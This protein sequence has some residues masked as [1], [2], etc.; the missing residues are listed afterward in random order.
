[1]RY[2]VTG[3]AG[4][5][6]SH[7]CAKLLRNDHEVLCVDNYCTGMKSNFA[8]LREQFGDK[9]EVLRHD[10]TLP[11]HIEVD[12]IF[13]LACP[14]SPIH[15]QFDPIKTTRTCILGMDNM[16]QLAS[17]LKVPILQ[18]STSE[19]YGDPQIHP[20][21]EEYR[22]W[23]DQTGIRS[24]Y[25]EG[26]RCAETLCFDY[27]RELGVDIKV[28]RIFNSYGPFMR[29]DDGRVVSNFV[30]QAL[31]D[32]PI[33]VYGDGKQ[34]RSFC[35]VKD[36][37]DGIVA[38]MNSKE[39]GPINIGNPTEITIIELV[40]AVMEI[41][42]EMKAQDCCSEI[43]HKDLPKDDPVR[44]CPDITKARKLIGWTPT[45]TLRDGL[46][47]TIGYFMGLGYGCNYAYK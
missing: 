30:V 26:K 22:G 27:Y 16:L 29:S 35:F 17:R 24:C 31:E 3:G 41:V 10:I 11:L 32:K 47:E 33:T 46:R 4:F 34:T 13:N 9:F 8:G 40:T 43:I 7:L 6:G 5:L 21:S 37:I 45:W 44:R 25:D 28:V 36:T 2:A 38:M 18:A 1:M 39:H 14:A 12:G 15:Y 19:V 23:V 20:Q 42:G